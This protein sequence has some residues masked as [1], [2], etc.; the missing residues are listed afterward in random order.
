MIIDGKQW[1][2][3]RSASLLPTSSMHMSELYD[4]IKRQRDITPILHVNW[5]QQVNFG[6]KNAQ[7]MRLFAGENFAD[8]FDANGLPLINATDRLFASLDQST[9]EFYIPEQELAQLSPEQ[10][11]ALFVQMNGSE[12]FADNL[13][14]KIDAALADDTPINIGQNDTQ[15]EQNTAKS[16]STRLKEI[17]QLD[18]G[19]TVYLRNIGRIPY[20]HIDS[21]L[22]FRQPIFDPKKANQ[23]DNLSNDLSENS[24]KGAIA[25][26]SPQQAN[27]LQQPNYLQSASFNQLRRVISKQVHYFDHPLFGMLVIINRYRWP[28]EPNDGVE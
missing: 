11:Q 17:W 20:L 27:Y 3:N 13:F 8:Q 16:R 6:R 23:I 4:K 22:D 18:G 21:S 14:A 5:R 12:T 25:V 28:E 1:Q 9:D 19:I 24:E 7:T 10:Q 2:Q 15:A 26:N